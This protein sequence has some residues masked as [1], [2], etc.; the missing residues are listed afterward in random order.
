MKTQFSQ[1]HKSPKRPIHLLTRSKI[2]SVSSQQAPHLVGHGEF[3]LSGH[4]GGICMDKKHLKE[5]RDSRQSG[6]QEI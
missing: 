1:K 3:L 5:G 2:R 6:Y 4:R